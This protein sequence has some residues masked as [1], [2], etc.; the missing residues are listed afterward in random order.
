VIWTFDMGIRSMMK[1]LYLGFELS[2]YADTEYHIIFYLLDNLY[3]F[4]DR[5]TRNFIMR[6]DKDWLKA[7]QSKQALD[8]K[9]KILTEFQRR[10][11]YENLCNKGIESYV[12]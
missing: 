12:R 1:Q 5:N 9:K 8:K 11:F 2:L 4:M 7:W 3:T 6:F 10:Y